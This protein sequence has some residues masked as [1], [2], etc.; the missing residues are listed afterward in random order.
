MFSVD[1]D[2]GEVTCMVHHIDT[3]DSHP[4]RQPPRRVPFA[5]RAK[6]SSMVKDMLSSGVVEES[7][8]PWASPI[9]LV[10]KRDSTLHILR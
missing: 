2:Q 5:R 7:N 8:S 4:L 6:I 1:E 10:K 9:V 3:G